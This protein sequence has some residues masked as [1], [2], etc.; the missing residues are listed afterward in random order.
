MIMKRQGRRPEQTLSKAMHSGG[1]EIIVNTIESPGFLMATPLTS[2]AGEYRMSGGPL[3]LILLWSR[4]FRGN[5]CRPARLVPR[6]VGGRA[7]SAT[8]KTESSCGGTKP[9][10]GAGRTT[11]GGPRSSRPLRRSRRGRRPPGGRAPKS[12]R[13]SGRRP[14]RWPRSGKPIR[15]RGRPRTAPCSPT[16]RWCEP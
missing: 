14:A 5:L 13:R 6:G 1:I 10:D 11:A 7:T 8:A 15:C 9:A 4:V 2:Q 16:P 12:A 3:C